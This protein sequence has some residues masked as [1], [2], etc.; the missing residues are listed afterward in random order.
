VTYIASLHRARKGHVCSYCK[1]PIKPGELYVQFYEHGMG[2]RYRLMI[3]KWCIKCAK[4]RAVEAMLILN[5]DKLCGVGYDY[6]CGKP[7]SEE[8]KR[9]LARL[10][11]K[12]PS[13][14]ALELLARRHGYSTLKVAIKDIALIKELEELERQGI[15]DSDW[16]K[17]VRVSVE[18][19]M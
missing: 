12:I 2:T 11:G 19:D 13:E 4:I 8:V 14:R 7:L 16:R 18:R 9:E 15:I 5:T 3:Y 17:I 10:V 6:P 1:K